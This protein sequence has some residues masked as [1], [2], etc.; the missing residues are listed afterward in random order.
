[1][2]GL[3]LFR[4][5]DVGFK[6]NLWIFF[7][8][9]FIVMLNYPL[10][11]AS[12]TALFFE[13]FG[14]KA[15]PTAWLL[16]VGLLVLAVYS[17]NRVQARHS[18]QR[19]FLLASVFTALV[20]FCG[21]LGFEFQSKPL[22]YLTFI[23][24][25]IYIVIQ[26]HLLLAYG[27]NYFSR[28]DFKLLVGPVGAVGSIGGILGGLLTAYIS[29][30]WGTLPVLWISLF[31]ILAPAL[32]FI[33]TP[34]IRTR[35]QAEGSEASPLS[36]LSES[37][38]KQYVFIIAAIIMLTQFII[39]IIDFRFS[40]AFEAA[41]T[42]TSERT[43]YLGRV[44][45]WTNFLT[46]LLQFFLLPVLLPRVSLK[47]IHLF[48]PLSYLLLVSVLI[49]QSPALGLV[50]ISLLYVYIKASDYSIFSG[51]K[52]ILYQPLGAAQK[53]GAKYLTDMIVYRA[54]KALI[55]TVL[56][57]VQSS[58]ILNMLMIFFIIVWAGLVIGLFRVHKKHFH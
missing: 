12:T 43:A 13:L 18:V 50:G 7:A 48:I 26:V 58:F 51:A 41:I 10:V 47:N 20:F 55:A 4:D 23:W 36:S 40:L 45:S 44:Y 16:S 33:S 9:Y 17:C 3:D 49:I 56:I 39:N 30:T 19:V 24:K 34:K 54:A 28:E 15:T 22:G 37:S 5:R 1:M 42:A 29:S 32:L 11:R 53:Y 2:L 25:E 52:E 6:K 35:S 8:A 31:F 46:F 57:Y 38:V 21:A 14:A 27:N